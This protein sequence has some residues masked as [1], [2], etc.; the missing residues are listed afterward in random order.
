MTRPKHPPEMRSSH[1]LRTSLPKGSRVLSYFAFAQAL[2]DGTVELLQAPDSSLCPFCKQSNPSGY[3]VRY[4]GRLYCM[5]CGPRERFCPQCRI[6]R[7]L[8]EFRLTRNRVETP[9]VICTRRNNRQRYHVMKAVKRDVPPSQR[10]HL[11][12]TERSASEF[13]RDGRY[14]SGLDPVCL[15]C[16]KEQWQFSDAQTKSRHKI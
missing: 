6:R 14:R 11:C 2:T 12:R 8:R 3:Y 4:R 9:C 7:S 13:A 1:Y 15:R 16:R 5:G 10:C